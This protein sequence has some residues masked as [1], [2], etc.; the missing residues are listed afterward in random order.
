MKSILL[1]FALL[2]VA[3]AAE[4]EMT[5]G[6]YSDLED[7]W[8]V[9]GSDIDQG[10]SPTADEEALLNKMGGETAKP[11][12]AASEQTWEQ[13]GYGR[14]SGPGEKESASQTVSRESDAKEKLR[15][16]REGSY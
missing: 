16:S 9:P 6:E 8:S 5:E 1:F 4:P 11:D 2:G 10:R 14:P 3:F 13:R 15:R 7:S 12:P